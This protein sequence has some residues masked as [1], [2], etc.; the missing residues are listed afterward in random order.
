MDEFVKIGSSLDSL[1]VIVMEHIWKQAGFAENRKP[2]TTDG[3]NPDSSSFTH[4]L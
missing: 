4:V 2:L 1:N 3:I